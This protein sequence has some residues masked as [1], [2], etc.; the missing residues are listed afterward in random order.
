MMF[1]IEGAGSVRTVVF[2]G[3]SQPDVQV[4]A[5]I[6]EDCHLP[7]HVHVTIAVG[8]LGRD[9]LCEARRREVQNFR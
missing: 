8:P 6:V 3:A 5:R 9:L 1:K 7:A 2:G 4:V